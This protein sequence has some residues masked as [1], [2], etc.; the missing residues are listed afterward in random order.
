MT[1]SDTPADFASAAMLRVLDHGMRSLG[2]QP[3]APQP[4]PG[5]ARVALDAKRL[6]VGAALQQGGWAALPL[7]GRGVHACVHEPTHRCL[8]ATSEPAALLA[9]WQ[10]LERYIHSR[11]RVQL[12]HAGAHALQ[13]AHR[14]LRAGTLPLPAEDLVVLGVLCALLEAI[15][16]VAVQAW[17]VSGPAEVAAWPRPDGDALARLAAAQA[18]ATWRIGWSGVGAAPQHTAAAGGPPPALW[19]DPRW[20]GAVGRVAALLAEQPGQPPTLGDLAA[21]CGLPPR[22]LQRRLAQAGTS[23]AALL[24]ELRARAAA[25]WLLASELPVAE[26]GFVSGYADQP[27]FT[28]QFRDRVG[29]PP[30]RYRAQFAPA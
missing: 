14:S 15:G 29:L 24:A 28:R 1:V 4:H 20:P 6:V 22:T 21:R 23:R 3:P 8:T 7:L 17:V 11:H 18:T 13:V 26:V 5:R 12:L 27:H 2:L 30:A 10:R 16:A 9:R 25:W 19:A